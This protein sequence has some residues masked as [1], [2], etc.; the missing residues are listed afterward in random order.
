LITVAD[1]IIE[2]SE[3]RG[4]ASFTILQEGREVMP[5]DVV[6][7][8]TH[9]LTASKEHLSRLTDL[10]R[11]A[12]TSRPEGR[13]FG[14]ESSRSQT[15]Q[16]QVADRIFSPSVTFALDKDSEELYIRVV[17]RET[18]EVLRE[19]PPAEMRKLAILLKENCGQLLDSFA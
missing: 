9:R 8:N 17:D 19:I 11:P 4:G 3:S 12:D 13:D 6:I 16:I 10:K 14:S 2:V 15:H 18:G 1:E 7:S 5:T